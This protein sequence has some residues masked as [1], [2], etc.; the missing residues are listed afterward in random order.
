MAPIDG[1]DGYGNLSPTSIRSPDR[2]ARIAQSLYRL[3]Y[4]GGN[5][6]DRFQLYL[7]HKTRKTVTSKDAFEVQVLLL[8][9]LIVPGSNLSRLT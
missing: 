2:P 8:T 3:R 1:L 7:L 9:S 5:S 6:A 4:P